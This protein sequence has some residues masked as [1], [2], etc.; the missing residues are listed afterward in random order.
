M[1]WMYHENECIIEINKNNINVLK[2]EKFTFLCSVLDF[3]TSVI[4]LTIRNE[5]QEQCIASRL[6]I[7]RSFNITERLGIQSRVNTWSIVNVKSIILAI[8]APFDSEEF[9]DQLYDHTTW[10]TDQPRAC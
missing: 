1:K 6:D 10:Y 9:G 4:I 8:I 3:K 2:R 5:F 7:L